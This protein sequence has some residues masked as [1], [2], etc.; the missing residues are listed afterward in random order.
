MQCSNEHVTWVHPPPYKDEALPTEQLRLR[1]PAAK[2][3]GC[4]HGLCTR[5]P[6][7][8]APSC[9]LSTNRRLQNFRRGRGLLLI[10]SQKAKLT[11]V[12]PHTGRV[13]VRL[14]NKV[15]KQNETLVIL[16][17]QQLALEGHPAEESTLSGTSCHCKPKPGRGGNGLQWEILRPRTEGQR[18][19]MERVKWHFLTWPGAL[20]RTGRKRSKKLRGRSKKG[21]RKGEIS[22]RH[23]G[24]LLTIS[25]SDPKDT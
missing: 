18:K 23:V 8:A 10:N 24:R 6:L 13:W 12:D 15:S 17:S 4:S 3:Y 21:D 22:A 19:G 9:S 25:K 7:G 16:I 2:L 11:E 14:F 5:S 1:A 20:G